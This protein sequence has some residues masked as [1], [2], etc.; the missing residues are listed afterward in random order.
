MKDFSGK[1]AVVTGGG[2]GI[3]RALVM[4]LAAQG[5]SVAICDIR[6]TEQAETKRLADAV[7]PQGVK[8]TI[9]VADVANEPQVEAFRDDVL[10]QHDTDHLHLLFNNAGIGGGGSFVSASRAEWDRTF[11]VCWGGVYNN[12]RAFLPLLIKAEAAHL[13]N[14]SSVNGFW[15]SLGPNTT[16]TAYSAAK[17]AVKGFTEALIG[18][19]KLNAPHVKVSLVMPGHVGTSIVLNTLSEHGWGGGSGVEMPEMLRQWGEDFRSRGLSPDRAAEII[20]TGVRADQWRILVGPDA[21]WL[22]QAVRAAPE[23]AY[24]AEFVPPWAQG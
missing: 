18:D 21:E 20:L 7:A 17:F 5:C 12:T 16:H 11:G 19:L 15:A 9:F 23:K 10:R 22:D 4:A 14:V 3:G 6:E 1:L 13:I 8:I 24:D 2:S